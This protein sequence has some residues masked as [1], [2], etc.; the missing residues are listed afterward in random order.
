MVQ[1][2]N[3]WKVKSLEDKIWKIGFPS[4]PYLIDSYEVLF[5][6]NFIVCNSENGRH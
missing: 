6:Y 3:F 2:I 4:E 1:C 5:E